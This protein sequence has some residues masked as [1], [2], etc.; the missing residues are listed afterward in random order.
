MQYCNFIYVYFLSAKEQREDVNGE[1]VVD[2]YCK[3]ESLPYSDATWEDST[4]IYKKWPEKINEFNS[5]EDSRTT[6][7]RHSKVLKYRP[8]FHQLREQPEYMGGDKVFIYISNKISNFNG[9][10]FVKR[11]NTLINYCFNLDVRAS[12]LSNGWS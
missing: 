12:R 9:A 5:R 2:Y 4:L 7:S 1:K 8:K 3:W 10:Q 11:S 6:P